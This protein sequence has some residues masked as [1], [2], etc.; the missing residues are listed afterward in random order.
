MI[1]ILISIIYKPNPNTSRFIDRTA[2]Y[3][4]A[5]INEYTKLKK[6]DNMQYAILGTACMILYILIR[7][8]IEQKYK[9]VLWGLQIGI[10][11]LVFLID[12]CI[13]LT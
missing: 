3:I 10:I 13:M 5:Y 8:I 1:G 9:S 11:N 7:Q 4:Q 6:G 12:Y 2:E